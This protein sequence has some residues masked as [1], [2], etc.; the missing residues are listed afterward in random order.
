MIGAVG[1]EAVKSANSS[2]ELVALLA[3]KKQLSHFFATTL[4]VWGS[5]GLLLLLLVFIVNRAETV[6]GVYLF[7]LR[8]SVLGL[9]FPYAFLI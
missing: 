1:P 7:M 6:L 4:V 8:F 2:C 3:L 5:H 9:H